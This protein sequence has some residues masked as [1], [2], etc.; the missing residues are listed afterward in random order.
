VFA[1]Y[2]EGSV[3]GGGGGGEME[4]EEEKR[5]EGSLRSSTHPCS[6]KLAARGKVRV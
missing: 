4:D 1:R 3:G 2:P 5:D 6:L